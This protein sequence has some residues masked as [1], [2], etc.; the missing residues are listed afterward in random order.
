MERV[1]EIMAMHD[2]NGNGKNDVAD[3]WIEYN[4]Y[5]EC[6]KDDKSSSG[7]YSSNSS[8]DSGGCFWIVF[9]IIFVLLALAECGA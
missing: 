1:A 3:D 8:S 2:W 6:M 5:Q 9:V 7:G 4:I